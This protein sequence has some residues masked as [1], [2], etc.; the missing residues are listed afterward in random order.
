MF[1]SAIFT[2]VQIIDEHFISYNSI[3]TYVFQ[4]YQSLMTITV[5]HLYIQR[6]S[7]L[8]LLCVE[9]HNLDTSINDV[10]CALVLSNT[11]S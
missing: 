7:T 10:R 4:L 11:I 6:N 3:Y 1:D 8:F 9:C 2:L 5:V